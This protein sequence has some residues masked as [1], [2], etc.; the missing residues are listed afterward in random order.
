MR[1]MRLAPV[2]ATCTDLTLA[3]GRVGLHHNVGGI[4]HLVAFV[5]VN[6]A[7]HVQ[8]SICRLTGP[9]ARLPSR[10]LIVQHRVLQLAV[11]LV[12]LDRVVLD[13]DGLGE[14]VE[15]ELLGVGHL[16]VLVVANLEV[17]A[18]TVAARVDDRKIIHHFRRIVRQGDDPEGAWRRIVDVVSD[19]I[20]GNHAFI[21]QGFT[22]IVTQRNQGR[23]NEMTLVI[24]HERILAPRRRKP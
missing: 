24:D 6:F 10:H 1:Q 22:V 8:P 19:D 5:T 3:T 4:H 18:G 15:A 16:A 17:V 12:D 7:V 13:G 2:G 20:W 9:P 11:G 21:L 14:F 23:F